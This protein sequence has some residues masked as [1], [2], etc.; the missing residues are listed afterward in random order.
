MVRFV[1]NNSETIEPIIGDVDP[2]PNLDLILAQASP[3]EAENLTLTGPAVTDSLANLEST[4]TA[5]RNETE[6]SSSIWMALATPIL[7]G[8]WLLGTIAWFALAL[9]RIVRFHRQVR[10]AAN[11]ASREL[12]NEAERLALRI[13]LTRCPPIHV[14]DGPISPMLWAGSGRSTIVLPRTLTMS[15]GD[16][17][18][19]QILAHELAHLVRRDHWGNLLSF[20]VTSLFWWNPVAWLARRELRTAAESCCDAMAINRLAGSRKSYAETLLAVVDFVTSTKP[21]KP[22]LATTFGA[23]RSLKR[24]IEMIANP[25]VKTSLSRSGLLLVACGVFSLTL[26]PARAQQ[27]APNTSNTAAE[28]QLDIVGRASDGITPAQA[29]RPS[30]ADDPSDVGAIPNVQQPADDTPA[31][32]DKR[33]AAG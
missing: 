5:S 15:I 19:R 14:V 12:Q 10:R 32:D 16:D 29:Q 20:V 22:T 25:N 33:A 7:I 28:K 21:F 30:T 6:A 8:A 17:Q 11:P 1:P 23:S 2:E 4:E 3:S 26:L 9:T 31:P 24:R 18:L 13:G 27:E